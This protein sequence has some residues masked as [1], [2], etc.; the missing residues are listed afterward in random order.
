MSEPLKK[1]NKKKYYDNISVGERTKQV[2][3]LVQI[4][5]KASMFEQFIKNSETKQT[6]VIA[7]SKRS[8]NELS[9]YL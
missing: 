4:Q 8:D 5:D 6:V 9:T 7:R 2:V 1:T 3:H